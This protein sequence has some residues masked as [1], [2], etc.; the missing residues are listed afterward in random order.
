RR[1]YRAGR[2]RVP[3]QRHG[4][5]GVEGG[6]PGL[7][8][9]DRLHPIRPAQGRG[10]EIRSRTIRTEEKEPQKSTRGTKG[11]DTKPT[12]PGFASFFFVTFV[13]LCGH[14]SSPQPFTAAA[15]A[16]ARVAA[17]TVAR[18]PAGPASRPGAPG[19]RPARS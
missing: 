9:A 16:P 2:R 12:R 5:G 7:P 1:A 6:E 13:P 18:A 3:A 10:E 11:S 17:R 4:G 8:A 19:A 15:G 14:S